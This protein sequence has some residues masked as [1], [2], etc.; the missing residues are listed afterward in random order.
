MF[1]TKTEAGLR[2]LKD[3]SIRLTPLQ[4][5]IFVMVDGRRTLEEILAATA[6]MGSTVDDMNALFAHGLVADAAPA[7]TAALREADD[8]DEEA[9]QRHR[10]RTDQERYAEAYPIATRLTSG[11]GLRGFRLNLAVEGAGDL[12]ALKQVAEKIHDAVGPAKFAELD[13]ALNHEDDSDFGESDDLLDDPDSSS[14][15]AEK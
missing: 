13:R 11:L 15:D 12:A 10:A 9:E 1:I 8:A 14:P 4:R 3:R 5:A 6:A 7:L 2:V